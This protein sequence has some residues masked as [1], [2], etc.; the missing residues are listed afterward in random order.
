[1][2]LEQLLRGMSHIEIRIPLSKQRERL[3]LDLRRDAVIRR[4]TLG[5]VAY[6]PSP[7]CR[8]RVIILRSC[9]SLRPIS[10]A[11]SMWVSFFSSA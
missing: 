11:A 10:D 6:A 8:I 1:M 3:V 9:R 2:D 5:T 7:S 4:L